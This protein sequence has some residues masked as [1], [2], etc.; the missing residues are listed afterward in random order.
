MAKDNN[1]N[2]SKYYRSGRSGSGKKE[3]RNIYRQCLHQG[4]EPPDLRDRR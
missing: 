4:S 2:A 1:Y 3:T